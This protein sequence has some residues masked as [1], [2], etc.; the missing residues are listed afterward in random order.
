VN[1]NPDAPSPTLVTA[2][3]DLFRNVPDDYGLLSPSDLQ[4]AI[5]ADPT[6]T[7]LDV[8]PEAHAGSDL[9]ALPGY[10][11]IP[12]GEL[13]AQK[14]TW[15][16]DLAAEIVVLAAD[17]HTATLAQS[18]LWMYGYLNAKTIPGGWQALAEKADL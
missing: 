10:L 8:D 1:A 6:L 18:I 12:F 17:D 3:V 4:A 5:Q 15:P 2:V 11:H 16:S 7:I 9:S 14:D 13:M